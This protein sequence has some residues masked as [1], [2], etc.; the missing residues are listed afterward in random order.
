MDL[1]YCMYSV[2]NSAD[3]AKLIASQTLNDN[4]SCV[5]FDVVS[6]FNIVPTDLAIQVAWQIFSKW[7]S[8]AERTR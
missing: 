2:H 6:L 7:P 3:F 8:L 1:M 4:K 5:S